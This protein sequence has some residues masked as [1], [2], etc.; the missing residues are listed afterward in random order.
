[1]TS[2]PLF[3]LFATLLSI[4]FLSP[5]A[6]ALAQSLRSGISL[7]GVIQ[8]ADTLRV[9]SS[10]PGRVLEIKAE[11]NDR[12]AQDQVLLVLKS[13]VQ[14]QQVEVAKL[15][16][17]INQ[18]NLEDRT[19]QK[20]LAALQVEVNGNSLLDRQRQLELARNQVAVNVNNVED[21]K[22]QLEVARLQVEVNGNN[23]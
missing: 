9:Q 10:V 11:E 12:V 8:P 6:T 1:M 22:K 19:Q 21:R 16:V 2:R 18:N 20:A 7:S 5:P 4:T 15:Q 14:A 13:D 23:L 17:R 3:A